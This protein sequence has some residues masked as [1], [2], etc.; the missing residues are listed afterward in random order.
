[1]YDLFLQIV[2]MGSLGVIIYIMALSIPRLDYADKPIGKIKQ[3]LSNIPL[4]KIDHF[5]TGYKERILRRIRLIT[6]K[7]DNLISSSLHK[8]KEENKEKEE[9]EDKTPLN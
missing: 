3:V 9:R 8:S 6:L 5:L 7:L 1:M 4:H 2:F